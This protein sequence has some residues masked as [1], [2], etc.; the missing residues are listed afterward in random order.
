MDL[1][2]FPR[3]LGKINFPHESTYTEWQGDYSTLIDFFQQN[4]RLLQVMFGQISVKN[5]NITVRM[6]ANKLI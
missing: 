6:D 2:K 1:D 4:K 3:K 5:S